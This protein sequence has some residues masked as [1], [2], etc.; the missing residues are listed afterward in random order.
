MSSP[1]DQ[2]GYLAG[3]TAFTPW[4]SRSTT[5]KPQPAAAGSG[6]GKP[7]EPPKAEAPNIEGLKSEDIPAQQRGG[8]HTISHRHRLSLRNYP[9][10][11]PPLK[12]QWFH[13]TDVPKRKPIIE[14]QAQ[15]QLPGVAK[16]YV[17]FSE[18]DSKAIEVAFQKLVVDEDTAEMDRLASGGTRDGPQEP[19]GSANPNMKED[20]QK[21]HVK[22]PV[23]EDFLFDVD[24]EAREL[25]PAYWLG[26]VYAVRRAT[27]FYQDGST[28][29]PCD[30]N[31]ATQLEE[32]YLKLK[33]WKFSSASGHQRSASQPRARPTS[34]RLAD[35]PNTN[36][37]V[38]NPVT[39]KA[40]IEDLGSVSMAGKTPTS[41]VPPD[42]DTALLQGATKSLRLFGAHMNSVVTYQD[43][44][45]AWLVTD[46]F[47]SRMSSTVYERFAGGAHFAG[48]KVVRGYVD[49]VKKTEV[50]DGKSHSVQASPQ[51]GPLSEDERSQTSH[52]ERSEL[53]VDQQGE[54]APLKP[55]ASEAR[56]RQLERQMSSLVEGG[57]MQDLEKEQEEVRKRDE[58]EIEEDYKEQE[59]DE[60]TRDIEHLILVTHGIGQRLGLRMDSINFVHDVNTLR[61]TLKTVYNESP[62]LQTLNGD[63]DHPT[64]NCRIQVLPIC[65]RGKLDFPKQSLKHNRRERDLGDLDYQDE[66]YPSLDDI[67]I[68]GVPTVRSLV[69]DLALDVLLYQSPTYKQHISRIVLEECN[70][71]YTLFKQRNP[72]FKGKV[73]LMGHSLGSAI[74]FEILCNQPSPSKPRSGSG[75]RRNTLRQPL[76]TLAF[77]VEDFYALGSPIALFQMLQGHVISARSSNSVSPPSSSDDISEDPGTAIVSPLCRRTFNIFHPTDPISYRIEPLISPSMALLKPQPLPYVKKGLFGTPVG[78]GLTGIGARVGQ[79]VTGLWNN[80]SNSVASSLL[81]RSLGITGEDATRLAG[82]S[83]AATL[84]GVPMAGIG[85]RIGAVDGKEQNKGGN[86]ENMEVEKGR[87]GKHPPT[88]LDSEIETL[89][90]GFK[91]VRADGEGIEKGGSEWLE[92]EDRARRIKREEGK[93][94]ALN[95]NG[96]VDYSIQ[97]GAFDISLLASIASHLSYWADEDVA[98]FI[99]SQLLAA[100][101]IVKGTKGKVDEKAEKAEK[102]EQ[103]DVSDLGDGKP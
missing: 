65:W 70:R 8:D 29:R 42:D 71:I 31:L 27:W 12:V 51:A 55:S 81:N 56:R 53:D 102:A 22:V 48:Q 101:R 19:E 41:K 92:F 1:P 15:D 80:L 58:K 18:G 34:L 79:S 33:P 14:S 96:R 62:N 35:D 78:Q 32:G 3:L 9:P 89:Y 60:Q 99:M 91:K 77:D 93:V 49:P 10:D 86:G 52:S 63:T 100:N 75:A 13:A 36:K 88:L 59:G 44:T 68:E 72:S 26:P 85:V 5:P 98:H 57:Q 16:K 83:G 61:K 94:R 66:D 73:S 64:K 4:G 25:M 47:L 2:K 43:A 103:G 30:E 87:D 38:S 6:G 39:P 28:L 11:C 97:E 76:P 67:T 20:K 82:P 84:A 54:G 23:N 37:P 40:S 46:D 69:T 74:M 21:D 90:S 24:I 17:P 7:Y 50:K 95:E 45:M